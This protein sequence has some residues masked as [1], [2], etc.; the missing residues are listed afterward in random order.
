MASGP[1]RDPHSPHERV[2]RRVGHKQPAHGDRA[3][4]AKARTTARDQPPIPPYR[5][6]VT[7]G[8]GKSRSK[9]I[10]RSLQRFKANRSEILPIVG[11]NDA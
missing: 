6:S 3:R 5:W 11:S 2:G 1:R 7:D 10:G 8:L 4:S 9:G